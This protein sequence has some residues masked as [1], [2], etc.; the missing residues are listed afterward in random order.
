MKVAI[1]LFSV[2]FLLILF[3]S[4]YLWAQS[5]DSLFVAKVSNNITS[6][7]LNQLGSGAPI[8]NGKKYIPDVRLDEHGHTLFINDQYTNGEFV[9]N[10]YAY[11]DKSLMYDLVYGQLVLLNFDKVG[12]IVVKSDM[13]DSF[14]LH[15]HKFINIKPAQIKDKE[16]TPGYYDLLYDGDVA[17]LAKRIKKITESTTQYKVERTV[18]QE[19]T[20]YLYKNNKYNLVKG[21]KSLLKLLHNTNPQNLQYIKSH[22]L[23]FRKSKEN[24][25]VELVKFHDSIMH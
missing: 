14:S 16:I 11:K 2:S 1:R 12:G 24:A 6:H 22:R 5:N 9:Y 15:N 21:K 13:V 10:G 25:M 20:Y 19:N 23:N 17:L 4:P 3:S 8:Y 18:A 7:Y